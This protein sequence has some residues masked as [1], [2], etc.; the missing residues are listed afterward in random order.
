MFMGLFSNLLLV[1]LGKFIGRKATVEERGLYMF[2]LSGYNI[3]NFSIPFV[4]SFFPAAIP[5]LAMFDMGN[6][7][8]VTGT[9]QAIVEL[10][11]GRKKHGFILQEIF[12]VLFRNPPFVVYIFMFILAIFGLSF[13]DEWLIPIRPLANANTLLSIFTIGLFMEFRLPKG[14]FKTCLKNMTW[15]YLLAFIL[16]SLVYFFLPFPAIIKEILLLIFFCP[17]SFLHMIQAIELGNDKALA[18]LTISLS[19]FISLIL[20]SIIVII[21]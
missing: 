6:S 20:M 7:L 13:P 12:G 15:R 21:L 17:M 11:S 3:G 2:D 4:S 19:M 18:G 1:F 14:K 9:T 5:F 8:M 10:S 16:A